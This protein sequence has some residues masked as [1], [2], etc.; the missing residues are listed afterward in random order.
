MQPGADEI[1]Y[2]ETADLTRVHGAVKREHEEPQAGAMALPLWLVAVIFVIGFGAAFYF[3]QFNGGFSATVL[4][5]REGMAGGGKAKGA[6]A[7]GPAVVEET[8]AQQGKKVYSLNCASCHQASGM[9]VPGKYPPLVKSEWVVGSS[10]KLG[11]VILKGLHG[12]ITVEGNQYND[13]MPAWGAS[14]SD[15]RIAAV[16]SY[17]RSEWGNSASEITPEQVGALRA[18]LASRSEPYVEADLKD[19]TGDIEVPAA[20]KP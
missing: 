2:R 1:D 12:P 14:L 18:E 5:E 16:M 3:G 8:L 20:A 7:G 19:V 15:K 10:R 11:K 17:I 4:N 9:G 13:A 6:G